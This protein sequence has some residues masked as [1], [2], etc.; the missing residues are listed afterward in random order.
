MER[1]QLLLQ[2]ICT[3]YKDILADNLVGIYVHGSIAMGCFTWET[4]DIDFIAVTEGTPTH[5]QKRALMEA[6]VA[7]NEEAPSKGLEM[8][9]LL[10]QDCQTF[11]HPMPFALHFSPTHLSWW[12]TNPEDYL[13]KMQGTDPDL[14]AHITVLHAHGK[15]LCGA[16][17][18]AT[19]APVPRTD[20][21]D[22]IRM[23]IGGAQEDI[24]S[25]PVYVVLNLCR[26]LAYVRE[27]LVLS[28]REGGQWAL[29]QMPEA[30]H[31]LIE[32]VLSTYAG[33]TILAPD[34]MAAEA[35]CLYVLPQ[36]MGAT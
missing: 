3:A 4:G 10:R 24:A 7:L 21:L 6:T 35:F 18:E 19:F 34:A 33:G 26:V 5:A 32:G 13:Q 15:V 31:P 25:N 17:I 14:A 12:Q 1:E 8:H 29:L 28:K 36:V 11:V 9:V 16:P 20:Y 2:R 30:Y 22:S 27:G 23:D